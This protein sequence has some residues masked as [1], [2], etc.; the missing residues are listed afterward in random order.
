MKRR[1]IRTIIYV[2]LCTVLSVSLCGCAIVPSLQLSEE[3]STLV[4]E[5]AAGKLLEY[6]K[7]H[8]G[9][10]MNVQE[11]DRADVNP[12]MQKPEPEES[13]L[14]PMPAEQPEE[15]ADAPAEEQPSDEGAEII[16]DASDEALVDAPEDVSS[17]TPEKSIAEALGIE[18]AEITYDHYDI[19]A[20]YPP[21]DAELAFS[22]KAVPGKQLL[23]V[24]FNLANPGSEDINA[25]TDSSGFKIRLM[26][27]GSEKLRGDVTFLDNDLM[28]YEGLLTPG[29]L[30]D[31]VLVFEIK[32]GEE[33]SSLDLLILDDNG[34]NRYPLM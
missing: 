26:L 1:K 23:V 29:A 9:G 8:P 27:N 20:T 15:A 12:G 19:A 24:H 25:K 7:G 11:I 3:Q 30:V 5:Y 13:E 32:E 18:G 17:S 33:V 22:M 34:E 21:E 16:P 2:C 10:L 4:A 14:P 31:A 6:A 28:N